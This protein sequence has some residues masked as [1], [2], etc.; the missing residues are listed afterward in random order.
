MDL[1]GRILMRA[2]VAHWVKFPQE[3]YTLRLC[4]S[5]SHRWRKPIG[6]RPVEEFFRRYVKPGD[7]VVDAGANVGIFTLAAATAATHSGRVYAFEPHPR[8]FKYL[9]RHLADNRASHV[10]A[11]NVALGDKE[12][13]VH[14]SD[15][16]LSDDINH[17]ASEGIE[18]PVKRLDA[19]VNEHVDLLKVDVEG[20]EKLTLEGAA[21]LLPQVQCMLI[22]VEQEKCERFGYTARQLIDLI[23]SHGFTILR[24]SGNTVSRV[25]V[26]F[27]PRQPED[28]VAA[29]DVTVFLKR[30]G[31]EL[32]DIPL[33]VPSFRKAR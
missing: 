6:S 28:L 13:A 31:Y 20:Y 17:V 3:G 11:F 5:T 2:G 32:G 21:S 16:L 12:G 29:R 26:G 14:F 19:L 9:Q 27:V 7:V 15:N 23:E 22:E 10:K 24:V 30:T 4:P 18:V 25:P 8:T 1:I 33:T